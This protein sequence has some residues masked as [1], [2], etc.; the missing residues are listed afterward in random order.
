MEKFCA[1]VGISTGVI[2]IAD[3]PMPAFG[4]PLVAQGVIL[5]EPRAEPRGDMWV[6]LQA[7]VRSAEK[8]PAWLVSLFREL[9]GAHHASPPRG[10]IDFKIL[11]DDPARNEL[12]V[13][14][15]GAATTLRNATLDGWNIEARLRDQTIVVSNVSISAAAEQLHVAGAYDLATQV[16]EA[17]LFNDIRPER[18][19]DLFPLAVRCWL[20]EQGILVRKFIKE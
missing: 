17:R 18:V 16:V 14:A 9:D 20:K 13:A 4:A 19:W 8:A 5:Y 1:T 10:R 15:E 2:R 3:L 12:F 6:E 11:P 7:L